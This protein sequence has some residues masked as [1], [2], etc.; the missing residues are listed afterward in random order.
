MKNKKQFTVYFLTVLASVILGSL[1]IDFFISGYGNFCELDKAIGHF[2]LICCL[3]AAV[4]AKRELV[5]FFEGEL[6]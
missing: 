5:K 3:F 6:V 1:T 4:D 2:F